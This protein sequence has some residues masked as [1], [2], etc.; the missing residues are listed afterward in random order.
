MYKYKYGG[1]KE[2]EKKACLNHSVSLKHI[3]GLQKAQLEN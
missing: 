3:T 1:W 2:K